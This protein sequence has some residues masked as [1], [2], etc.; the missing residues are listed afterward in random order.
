MADMDKT[1]LQL[2]ANMTTTELTVQTTQLSQVCEA[3]K[4]VCKTIRFGSEFCMYNLPNLDEIKTAYKTAYEAGKSFT[5]ITPRLSDDAISEVRKHLTL[6]NSFGSVK[7]VANDF[8][9]L[10]VMRELSNLK[11][12][13]GRQLVYTPSRCPWK[14]ISEQDVNIFTKKKLE[15]IFY[16]TSLNYLPS[17][18]FF[19]ELGVTGLD[20]D[21][22][23][24]LFR[25]LDQLTQNKLNVSVHLQA[26]PVA[27]TRKC[28][29]SRFQGEELEHCSKKCISEAY[30]MENSQLKT[31]L[32]LLGNAVFRMEEPKS[33]DVSEL[34]R[35]GIAE[36]VV[37][38]SP[39]TNILSAAQLDAFAHKIKVF[40]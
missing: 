12:H 18:K 25:N 21:W 16:Q 26:V 39:L 9:T 8:G 1:A 5:Y 19:K 30:S 32:F 10:R 40:N 35:S 31:S 33:S 38:M 14:Q 36:L 37:T 13:L 2:G 34:K 22:I 28:H 6:L 11:P 23:P 20:I 15:Q 17:I 27:I 3:S 24:Q 29:T 4:S 7:V